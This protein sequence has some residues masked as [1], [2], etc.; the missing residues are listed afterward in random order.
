MGLVCGNPIHDKLYRSWRGADTNTNRLINLQSPSLD[1]RVAG[2]KEKVEGLV[3]YV[4]TAKGKPDWSD[5]CEMAGRKKGKLLMRLHRGEAGR[6]ISFPGDLFGR[7][8]PG[9]LLQ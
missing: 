5:L 4:G 2:D 1:H 3:V 6:G 7:E 9:H 8:L